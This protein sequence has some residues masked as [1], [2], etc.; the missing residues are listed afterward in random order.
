MLCADYESRNVPY[1]GALVGRVANRISNASFTLDG[2]EYRLNINNIGKH[3]LH[4][5]IVGWDKVG[6]SIKDHLV[7]IY[8]SL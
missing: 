7:I 1:F 3:H 8:I 6:G 4:G 5:G 2:I